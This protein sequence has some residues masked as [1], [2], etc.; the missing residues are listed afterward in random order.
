MSKLRVLII[1][2]SVTI[3][4]ILE[5]LV[6][7]AGGCQVVGVASNVVDGRESIATCVPDVITLDL[8]M[9]DV[10]GWSLLDELR[11]SKHVPVVVIS[12]STPVG[13]ATGAEAI[14]RGAAAFFDKALLMK[15]TKDLI[16]LL[17]K[18]ALDHQRGQLT[19]S[20]H[21]VRWLDS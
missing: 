4:A 17:R 12:S 6:E 10:D 1:D 8:A 20:E 14:E 7:K 2:D 19:D 3:R 9:P 5:S 21:K 11:E 13:S 15:Q 18:L 16:S